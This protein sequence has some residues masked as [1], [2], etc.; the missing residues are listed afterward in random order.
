M[1]VSSEKAGLYFAVHPYTEVTTV[2]Q[3]YHT[4]GTEFRYNNL[5]VSLDLKNWVE[6]KLPETVLYFKNAELF[7]LGGYFQLDAAIPF[8][9]EEQAYVDEIA[10]KAEDAGKRYG[11]PGCKI[12]PYVLWYDE[13][14]E[15]LMANAIMTN[16]EHVKSSDGLYVQVYDNTRCVST[17]DVE[18]TYNLREKGYDI[19]YNADQTGM[20]MVR[21]SDNSVVIPNIPLAKNTESEAPSLS[22]PLSYYE[23]ILLPYLK[24]YII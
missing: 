20:V 9:P 7:D 17:T 15:F 4:E 19:Q 21:M 2:S 1:I 18:R 12:E 14:R 5:Y 8:T 23:N 13:I 22:T 11:K 24:E 3:A 6:I 10:Q 16:K